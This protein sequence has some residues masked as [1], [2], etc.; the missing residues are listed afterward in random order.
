MCYL[1]DF[2]IIVS[3][4][5]QK[6]KKGYGID[7]M[8]SIRFSIIPSEQGSALQVLGRSQSLFCHW[9]SLEVA[10]QNYICLIFGSNAH[11]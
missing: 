7:I 10:H 1:F 3:L 5:S 6:K 8:I 4:E 11:L 2:T 9:L